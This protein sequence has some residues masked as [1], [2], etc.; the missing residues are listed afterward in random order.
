M[1][2]CV[3]KEVNCGWHLVTWSCL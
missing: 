3:D 1:E 2:L